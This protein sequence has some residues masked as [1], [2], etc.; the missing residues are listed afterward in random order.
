MNLFLQNNCYDILASKVLSE[1]LISKGLLAPTFNSASKI[2]S[3]VL[4]RKKPVLWLLI[5]IRIIWRTDSLK[6]DVSS[7]IFH[8][9]INSQLFIVVTSYDSNRWL[10]FVRQ[11]RHLLY[12]NSG[13]FLSYNS[14]VSVNRSFK[15]VIKQYVTYF[16]YGTRHC[17]KK[18]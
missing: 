4:P 17:T 13:L 18:E 12:N 5:K 15:I 14:T 6:L 11:C 10:L 1:K 3:V 2:I 8:H 16:I 7:F 9:C